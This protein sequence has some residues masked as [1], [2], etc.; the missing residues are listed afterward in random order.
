MAERIPYY[1][2]GR[3]ATLGEAAIAVATPWHQ[4]FESFPLVELR[5]EFQQAEHDLLL[6]MA[7]ARLQAQTDESNA[8]AALALSNGREIQKPSQ[9]YYRLRSQC[10]KLL[11]Q[12]GAAQRDLALADAATTVLTAQDWFLRGES[13]RSED[14]GASAAWLH[15]KSKSQRVHLVEAVEAYRQALRLDPREYWARYQLGRC[16]LALGGTSEAIEAFGGCIALRSDVPWGYGARGLACALAGRRDEAI[17]DLNKAI[18]ID[19]AFQ[20]AA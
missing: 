20:P 18:E 17:A 12:Q 2:M 9:G 8:R 4:R 11:K 1:D 5:A 14:W 16:L 15:D 19:P 3:A 10:L 13:R 7:R 6:V